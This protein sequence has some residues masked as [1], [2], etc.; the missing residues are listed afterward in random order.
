MLAGDLPVLA[1][2][3]D[4]R[5]PALQPYEGRAFIVILPPEMTAALKALGR[6]EKAT[7][8][9]TLLAAYNVLLYRYTGQ[10]DVV[11][12]F[13]VAGRNELDTEGMIGLFVNTLPFRSKV[14]PSD[15]FLALLRQVKAAALDC[16][17]Q[18]GHP[19][20]EARGTTRSTPDCWTG[21]RCSRHCSS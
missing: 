12:G 3:T 14:S 7:L 9:M 6:K 1:L 13:P 20:R 2:P 17:R 8:F 15:S 5:R 4:Y 16:L 19:V 21:R 10:D 11:V 18:P